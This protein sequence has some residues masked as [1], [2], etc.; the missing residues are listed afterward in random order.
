MLYNFPFNSFYAADYILIQKQDSTGN[1]IDMIPERCGWISVQIHRVQSALFRV[2][3]SMTQD[4]AYSQANNTHTEFPRG[5]LFKKTPQQLNCPERRVK[6][7]ESI[8][9]WPVFI[10]PTPLWSLRNSKILSAVPNTAL[11]LRVEQP[12]QCTFPVKNI[13]FPKTLLKSNIK[14]RLFFF[15]KI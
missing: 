8:F 11:G 6:S 1:K 2:S 7:N 15:G 5:S 4:I 3:K 14:G 10:S 13:I 9:T 12:P